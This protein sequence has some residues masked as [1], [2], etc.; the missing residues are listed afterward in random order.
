MTLGVL[1]THK[2]SHNKYIHYAIPI[3]DRGSIK[4]AILAQKIHPCVMI[5]CIGYKKYSTDCQDKAYTVIK[6]IV[7]DQ[8]YCP[9]TLS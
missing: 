4:K 7:S 9:F 6:V 5:H 3:I 2:N 1:E 8:D